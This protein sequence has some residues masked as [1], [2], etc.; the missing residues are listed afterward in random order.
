MRE[1]IRGHQRSSEVIRG[2]QRSSEVI[3]GHQHAAY[4]GLVGQQVERLTAAQCLS[5][6]VGERLDLQPDATAPASDE[7]VCNAPLE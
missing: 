7:I 1:V 4:Q 5:S 3:R 2:H 6:R